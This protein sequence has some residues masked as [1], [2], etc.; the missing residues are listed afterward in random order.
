MGHWWETYP[1]RQI[2][3][4]LREIDMIDIRA[5]QVVRDLQAFEATLL[6]INAAGII[7]SYPTDLPFHFQSPYLTGDSLAQIIDACHAAG[8]R[9]VARTD[10]SKVRRPIYE[11]HPEWAY[12]S[13]AGDVVDYNGDIAVC[14]NGDY[15][16]Q[17]ATQIIE[18]CLTK[19]DFDGIFFN[20]GGYQTRDYS[21]N[22][23][24]PCQCENCRRRFAEMFG[25][26]LP[27]K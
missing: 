22:Y 25:A 9:V 1:W 4:N 8:I 17:Y 16:Q 13:P 20:M 5:E 12:I 7:A 14:I 6:M 11:M 15:Q 24:G 3:T 26:A 10:F 19:L 27:T 2:Q 21:G 23:Y 18:E